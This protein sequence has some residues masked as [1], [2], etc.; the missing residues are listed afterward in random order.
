MPVQ[1]PPRVKL[2]SGDIVRGI[3]VRNISLNQ[4][5]TFRIVRELRDNNRWFVFRWSEKMNDS[6]LG[7]WSVESVEIIFSAN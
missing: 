7:G 1:R 3:Y 5:L 2:V 4:A 6:G